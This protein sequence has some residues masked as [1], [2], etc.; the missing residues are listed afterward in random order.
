MQYSPKLKRIMQEFKDILKRE[1][2]A[3]I[4]VVHEPGYSESLV[5]IEPSYSAAKINRLENSVEFKSAIKHYPSM[6]AR[7]KALTD[8]ANMLSHLSVMTGKI[9]INLCDASA[10]IDKKIAAIHGGGGYTSQD[11]QNN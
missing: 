2:I 6:E 3:A 1:D 11:A 4:I 9:A 5:H 10:Y 7:H 8:T